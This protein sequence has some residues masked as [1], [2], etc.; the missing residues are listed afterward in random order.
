M[1]KVRTKK[2]QINESYVKN[3]VEN[4]DCIFI[5]LEVLKNYK[6]MVTYKCKKDHENVKRFDQISAMKE[7]ICSECNE[8]LKKENE[9]K[10][11][12]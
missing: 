1:S 3:Y 11:K 2:V 6:K 9:N 4:L 7:R 5:K 8:L 10:N 12:K